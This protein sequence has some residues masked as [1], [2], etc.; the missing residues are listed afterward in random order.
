MLVHHVVYADGSVKHLEFSRQSW[1]DAMHD[2]EIFA[3]WAHDPADCFD[4][5][6]RV[7]ANP[8]TTQV[9]RRSSWRRPSL[10]TEKST[11]S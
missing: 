11:S 1:E 5:V 8:F 2:S 3:H 10:S 6:E 9:R 4:P 7:R